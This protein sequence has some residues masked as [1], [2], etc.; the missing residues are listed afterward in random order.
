MKETYSEKL[1]AAITTIKDDAIAAILNA[2]KFK[3]SLRD[4]AG[5]L[6]EIFFEN[7]IGVWQA[8]EIDP[9]DG[10]VMCIS[11]DD[12]EEHWFWLKDELPVEFVCE[13]ADYLLNKIA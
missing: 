5:D 7:A 8:A 4:D 3:P 6:P 13:I 2:A 9:N 12:G 11:D 10:S 1:S